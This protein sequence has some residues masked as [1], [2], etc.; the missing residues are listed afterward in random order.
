M[1]YVDPATAAIVRITL[2]LLDLSSAHGDPFDE[3]R[4]VLDYAPFDIGGRAYW[5]LA[6]A[7]MTARIGDTE[8]RN[9]MEFT[10]YRKY[11]AESVIPFTPEG[12]EPASSEPNSPAANPSK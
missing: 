4:V 12:G 11:N 3:G 9:D 2:R 8:Q 6:K 1:V 7:A 10:G 5:L